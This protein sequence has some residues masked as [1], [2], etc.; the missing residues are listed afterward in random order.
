MKS[1]V[2]M[3][4]TTESPAITDRNL[5]LVGLGIILWAAKQKPKWD[6]QRAML[7]K[8]PKE[9]RGDSDSLY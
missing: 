9:Y 1:C 5:I 3:M 2:V 8:R 6:R 7:I 4:P